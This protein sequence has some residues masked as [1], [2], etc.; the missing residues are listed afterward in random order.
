KLPGE[1]RG[2]FRFLHVSTDEV[3]GSLG[4]DGFFSETTPYAPNSPY[5][6]S[7]A[8]AD[9]LARAWHRTYGLPVLTTNCSNNYGPC[10]FPE[11]LIPHIILSAL[12]NRPLPVYGD[13]GNTRDWLYV[14]DHCRALAAALERGVPGEVYAIGG[15]CE[16][17]N[18]E[19]VRFICEVLDGLCPREDGRPYGERI[20]FVR[21]RPGHDRR[22]AV[23]A[24]KIRNELGWKPQWSFEEGMKKTIAWYRENER[25]TENILNGSYRLE[26]RG[27]GGRT[28]P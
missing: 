5:S 23:D 28:T 14:E 24:A 17:T 9:H 18:L 15:G 20:V 27:A 21:D 8:G 4:P 16:K 25:W 3:F 11:K 13:G 10:Q 12:K 22:Y 7:K 1:E 19:I 2:S 26:R 6:A